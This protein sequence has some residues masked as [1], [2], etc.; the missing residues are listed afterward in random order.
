VSPSKLVHHDDVAT[1]LCAAVI[2]HGSPGVYNL[3][4]PGQLTIT[5][6]AHA[7]GWHAVPAPPLAVGV[8]AEAVS[9]MSFLPDEAAWI[10]AVRRPVL[11]ETAN[12]RRKLHWM[13][14]HDAGETLQQTIAAVRAR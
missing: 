4:A 13:P 2:D 8:A 12:A 1:A 9:L 7:L 11:M 6:L 3:A 5:D 10:E 14:H